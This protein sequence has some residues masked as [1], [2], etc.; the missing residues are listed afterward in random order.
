MDTIQAFWQRFL[1]ALNKPENTKYI[2]CFHFELTEH[3]ANELL[4]LVLKGQKKATASSLLAYEIEKEPLPKIGELSIVTDFNGTPRCV[5]ET[6]AVT[7]IPFNEMTY[8][9]C[10]R[11][12]ED[13][14][15]ES[16]QAGHRKFFSA[17]GKIVGYEFR[18]D[19]PVVFEDFK[20]IYQED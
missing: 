20:V 8:E 9:I 10:K 13:D 16:W 19:L 4:A 5:I 2:S 14:T 7:I 18:E 1:K 15:L 3:L 12:G 11:E 17:E 6:Q